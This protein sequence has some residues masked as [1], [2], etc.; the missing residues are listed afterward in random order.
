MAALGLAVPQALLVGAG[1][2]I[3]ASAVLYNLDKK[4]SLRDNPFAYVLAAK[5]TFS[6]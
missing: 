3:T 2:S 6:S 1:I 4:K 5:K